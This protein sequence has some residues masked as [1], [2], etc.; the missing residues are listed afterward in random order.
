MQRGQIV[1]SKAGRDK[2]CFFA[3]LKVEGNRCAVADGKKRRVE[4]PKLKNVKHLG[5]TNSFIVEED[6]FYNGRVWK[7]LAGYSEHDDSERRHL[8]V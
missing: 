7:K 8:N 6:L 4:R 5:F 3:V 2:G 1:Y